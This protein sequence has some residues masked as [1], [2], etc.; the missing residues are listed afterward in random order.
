MGADKL[1][2]SRYADKAG[3]FEISIQPDQDCC[4]L[5]VPKHPSTGSSEE[6][7]AKAEALFD[8]GSL[9]KSCVE[10]STNEW[11]DPSWPGPAVEK[12]RV[13]LV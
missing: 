3:T 11:I 2:I 12:D 7:V 10:A 13:A 1:E 9:V 5:F 8:V 4:T 6:E